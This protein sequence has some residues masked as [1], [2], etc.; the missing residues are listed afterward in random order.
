MINVI[1]EQVGSASGERKSE[2]EIALMASLRRGAGLVVAAATTALVAACGSTAQAVSPHPEPRAKQAV[3]STSLATATPSSSPAITPTPTPSSSPSP[4]NQKCA[5]ETVPG[6]T[7]PRIA[8]IHVANSA[9]VFTAPNILGPATYSLESTDVSGCPQGFPEPFPS[10]LGGSGIDAQYTACSKYSWTSGF[11]WDNLFAVAS[12]APP[13]PMPS[14]DLVT[15]TARNPRESG[16]NTAS[17]PSGT[18]TLCSVDSVQQGGTPYY[19]FTIK[20]FPVTV[21]IENSLPKGTSSGLEVEQQPSYGTFIADP[22]GGTARTIAD[23]GDIS[24]FGMY[25]AVPGAAVQQ[26]PSAGAATE[27]FSA[28]YS[29]PTSSTGPYAGTSVLINAVLNVATGQLDTT[30]GSCV[31][32]PGPNS[33]NA[34]FCNMNLV[35]APGAPQT[36]FV[37]V[38]P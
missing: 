35:G 14:G 30:Q 7:P 20:N 8:C 2:M 18:Y 37:E 25:G 22:N 1:K 15:V 29:V 6:G 13:A 12:Y 16:S 34:P 24:L 28:S 38:H 21:A 31:V 11:Y 17:C 33:A 23:G 9:Q 5:Q 3:A 32:T 4:P 10:A 27:G 26:S 19:E 36:I